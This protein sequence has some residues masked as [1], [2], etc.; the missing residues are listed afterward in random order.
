[1]LGVAMRGVGAAEQIGLLGACRHAGGRSAALHI[2][3]GDRN[4]C[5]VG[6]PNEFRHQGNARTGGRGKGTRTVPASTH[7]HADR[8]QFIFRLHDGHIAASGVLV[9]TVLVAIFLERLGHRRRGCDR[10][11]GSHRCT[12]IDATQGGSAVA[13]GEDLV[14]HLVGAA[15]AQADRRTQVLRDIVAPQMKCTHVGVEQHLLAAV[16]L[17]KEFLEHLGFDVEQHRER[18]D[19]DDVLEQLALARVGISRVGDLGQRNA[20]DLDVLAKTRFGNRPRAV[21]KQVAAALNFA[22]IVVPGLR[23]HGNHHVHTTTPATVALFTDAGFVPGRHALNIAGED[24]ART[25]RHTHA[26][27]GLGKQFV[28]RG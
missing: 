12:A 1:M 23:I 18:T 17:G 22:Y 26:H 25:D 3:D 6:Q 9:D 19:V 14:T 13:V 27:D 28:G 4:F 15:H 11:P 16:L 10:I 8:S 7:H 24:V 2:D 20:D 21:I 5:K